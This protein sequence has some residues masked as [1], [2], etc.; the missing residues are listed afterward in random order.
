MQVSAAVRAVH[1][2][3][4]ACRTLDPT[5]IIITGKRL[6][7][8]FLGISDIVLFDPNE[9]FNV[10]NHYQQ[11]D[12][13]SLGKLMLA[14]ACKSLQS[15]QRE[16]IQASIDM[17]SRIYS[18]DLRHLIIYLL[19]T[20]TER[21]ITEIMPMIGARFYV[22]LDALQSQVDILEEELSK[23]LENG[24]LYRLLVKLAS[25][26]ERPE[27]NMDLSW[28]ETGDRYMLKLFRDYL[29]HAVTAEGKPWM[30]NAHIVQNLNKLDCGAQ[31]KVQLVSRDEQSVL[32]VTYNEL[33]N[34]LDRAFQE[35]LDASY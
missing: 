26:N 31:E 19:T 2:S 12:L 32:V 5:K 8:S 13:T 4:L 6:R 21:T 3:G 27:F 29:F 30:S 9:S 35:L 22:Q 24:R 18:A 16:R 14:L 28:S 25:I 1:Q 33:K 17:I 20:N 34:C 7:L 11:E 23:E 10:I 15:I